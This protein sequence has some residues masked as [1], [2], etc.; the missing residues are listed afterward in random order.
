MNTEKT[1]IFIWNLEKEF[2]YLPDNLK[3]Q[4]YD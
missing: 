2:V 1:L 4:V 3:R